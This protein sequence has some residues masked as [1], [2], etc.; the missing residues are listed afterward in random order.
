MPVEKNGG[1]DE[2]IFREVQRFGPGWVWMI[3]APIAALSWF[4]AVYQVLL[5]RPFGDRPAP[6]ALVVIIWLLF[7]LGL[8][9]LIYSIRLGVEVGVDGVYYRFFPFHRRLH[10]IPYG[11]IESC[12]ARSYRP[13]RE[14]GGWGIRWGRRGRAYNIKG[15]RG[16]QLLLTSGE[17]LLLGSQRADELAAAINRARS[18]SGSA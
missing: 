1:G 14:Y 4:V 3:V 10:A 2:A 15:D 16:V 12:E 8:P 13:I 17:G 11:E 18:R 5:G 9:I 6:D 7:G